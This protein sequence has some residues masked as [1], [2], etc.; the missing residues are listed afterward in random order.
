MNYSKL[1]AN[2]LAPLASCVF[3]CSLYLLS[4]ILTSGTCFVASSIRVCYK[5]ISTL[6]HIRELGQRLVVH[7]VNPRLNEDAVFGL[8]LEVL[9]HVVHDHSLPEIPSQFAQVLNEGRTDRDRVLPVQPVL[10]P[11]LL[12]VH[13]VYGPIR[14]LISDYTDPPYIGHSCR[15]YHYLVQV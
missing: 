12:L 8:Q 15:V 11:L 3:I 9:G 4:A 13:R 1:Y 6:K 5:E 7:V 2:S 10:Y 14:V